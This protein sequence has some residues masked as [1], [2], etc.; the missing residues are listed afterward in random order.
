MKEKSFKYFYDMI[1]KSVDIFNY[2]GRNDNAVIIECAT[3]MYIEQMRIK[4]YG[5]TGYSEQY[6]A[7]ED[8]DN[9]E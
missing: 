6:E 5:P 2:N 4:A 8:L 3:R 9:Y 1:S 7:Q